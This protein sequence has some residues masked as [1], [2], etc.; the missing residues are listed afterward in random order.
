MVLICIS[1]V[2]SDA[3][4]LFM[5]LLAICMLW[6]DV[7]SDPLPVFKSDVFSLLSCE[8]SLCI[9]YVN[10]LLDKWFTDLFLPACKLALHFVAG[11][12]GC[13]EAFGFYPVV[14][15][16]GHGA[17]SR[18]RTLCVRLSVAAQ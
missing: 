4:R 17:G 2:I 7:Y 18:C 9:F 6:K 16:M 15:R 12:L 8:S 10:L 14:E 1:L 3:E 13:A 5:F 11:V